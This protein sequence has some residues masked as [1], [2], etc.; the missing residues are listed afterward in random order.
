[1]ALITYDLS[2]KAGALNSAFYS[3]VSLG[4]MLM[5][6]FTF[7]FI[8]SLDSKT[9]IFG[10]LTPLISSVSLPIYGIHAIIL[11]LVTYMRPANILID[12]PVTLSFVLAS[13]LCFG[14]LVRKVDRFKIFS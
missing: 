6:V 5:A 13:S 2:V 11:G 12:I 9:M 3:Y 10:G 1:I 14:I 7:L 8:K 4:V